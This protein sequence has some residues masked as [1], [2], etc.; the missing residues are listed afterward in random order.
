MTRNSPHFGSYQKDGE[1]LADTVY[2]LTL[3]EAVRFNGKPRQR[4]I[5]YLG[6][7]SQSAIDLD[8]ANQRGYFWNEVLEKLDQLDNQILPE[9]RAKI[10]AKIAERVPRL[11]EEEKRVGRIAAQRFGGA[12]DFR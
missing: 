11:T 6:S 1:R 10:E 9:D 2:Y 7:I 3:V 8:T 4:H 12:G 5:A